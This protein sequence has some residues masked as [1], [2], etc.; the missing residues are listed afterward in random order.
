MNVVV[1]LMAD[2]YSAITQTVSELSA[3]GAR[4][5]MLWV[6]MAA[7]YSL[8]L[9]AF[10]CGVLMA[11]AAERRLR[12][13]GGLFITQAVVGLFWPPMHQREVLAAG[14][15][16]VT[17]TLH[18]VFTA[19]WGL[20][21]MLAIVLATA[22]SGMLF[23]IYSAITLVTIVVFGVLTS[24]EAPAMQAN[25]ATPWIGV[26]ERIGMGAFMLWMIV[27]AAALLR[28]RRSDVSPVT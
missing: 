27:F 15:G 3:I 13:V 8:L 10:G 24:A 19:F 14:G 2:E 16:T 20:T 4:T 6:W 25:L 11:T 22:A 23:R 28:R 1:P 5:R 12:I 18:I 21:S 7:F 26:F 9:A 17:D